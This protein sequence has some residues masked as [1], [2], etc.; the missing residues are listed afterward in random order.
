MTDVNRTPE[1]PPASSPRPSR[2]HF[3]RWA[4]IATAVAALGTVV[5]L[6]AYAHGGFAGWHRGGL[7]SAH[8]DPAQLDAH[9]DRMLKHL[10]VEIDATDAQK[11]ALGPVV[12]A[13]V[14]D[15]LPLHERLHSTRDQAVALLTQ[16][17]IDRAALESLRAS[18]LA[19]AEQA[20]KRL[21]QALADMADVLTPDQRKAIAE[22]MARRH[23][24]RG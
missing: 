21:A 23:G 3:F 12:K 5:G 20:S 19:V 9:L 18:Q 1:Q 16:P 15:L 11:Q 22:H 7:M 10:Y 24:S 17:T 6:K 4:A 13:A 14:R 2:R 8:L